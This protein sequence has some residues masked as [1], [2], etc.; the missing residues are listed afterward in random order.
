MA[1]AC[2]NAKTSSQ[3]PAMVA[4]V[5]AA[6]VLVEACFALPGFALA[7]AVSIVTTLLSLLA[8]SAL[9]EESASDTHSV[10]ERSKILR[11]SPVSD[12][13]WRIAAYVKNGGKRRVLREVQYLCFLDRTRLPAEAQ[14]R[15]SAIGKQIL[16]PSAA[17]EIS[18]LNKITEG[19]LRSPARAKATIYSPSDLFPTAA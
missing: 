18:M 1:T 8:S 10:M 7:F 5:S 13:P 14:R 17:K 16:S 6:A 9:L 19:E 11:S 12:L 3:L 15:T 2:R 4:N